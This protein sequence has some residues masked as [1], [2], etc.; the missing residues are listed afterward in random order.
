MPKTNVE[1]ATDNITVYRYCKNGCVYC[2]AWRI[3][4]FS[5]RIEKGKYNPVEEA[6]KYLKIRDRRVIVISFTSDPY[7]FEEVVWKITRRVL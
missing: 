6:R 2:W 5:K 4:L 7:P 3:P 1:Y